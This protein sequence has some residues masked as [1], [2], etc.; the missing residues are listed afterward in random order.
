MNYEDLINCIIEW[1]SDPCLI[2][3]EEDTIDWLDTIEN[4]SI[5]REITDPEEYQIAKRKLNLE[6]NTTRK[7]YS[8]VN[9]SEGTY[10]LS[11]D[12]DY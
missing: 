7:I 11:E 10:C 3:T 2:E 8:F 1:G 9:G 6:N 5:I 12:W 4:A